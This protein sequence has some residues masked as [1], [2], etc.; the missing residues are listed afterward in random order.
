MGASDTADP[1]LLAIVGPTS[2]GKTALERE[3]EQ[4]GVAALHARLAQVD[5]AAAGSIA[6]SNVRRVV[7]ALEVY[8]ITG[9]PISEQRMIAAPPYRTRTLWLALPAA[10][11]YPRIDARV[12]TMIAAGL[13]DEVRGL[14]E[15]GYGWDLPAMSGLGYREFRPYFEGS[16]TLE[17]AVLR[18]KYDT[19]AFARRQPAWFRRLPAVGQ[20]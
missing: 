20:L 5:S 19:H 2:V 6:P 13:L 16:A 8:A 1:A 7:R 18:L 12:D 17:E 10:E 3:A 15:R 9:R 11:L 14:L 4:R